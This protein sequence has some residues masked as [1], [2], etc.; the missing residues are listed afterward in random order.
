V[1]ARAQTAPASWLPT[2]T[3]PNQKA[4]PRASWADLL[5][6]TTTGRLGFVR[7]LAAMK[8]SRWRPTTRAWR[9][10]PAIPARRPPKSSKPFSQLGGRAQWAPNEK[11]AARSRARRGLRRGAGV[12]HDETRRPQRR[13]RPAVHRR[14][15]RRDGALVVVSADDPGL[16]PARTSRTTAAT[17][18]PPPC[19]CWSRRIRRRPTISPPPPSK[20]SERWKTPVL[21]RITTRVCHSKSIVAPRRCRRR[22]RPPHF[23]HDS[24]AG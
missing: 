9:S 10:A 2:V 21:L 23:E 16:A 7:R 24:K 1:L 8:R 20:L 13:R 19:R 14:L 4:V 5:L 11:V 6:S 15:H 22:R 18:S 17:P 12:A 3:Q